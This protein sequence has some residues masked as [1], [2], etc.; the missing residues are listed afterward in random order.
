M[1]GNIFHILNRGVEKRK[2]YMHNKDYVRF[3]HDLYDFNDIQNAVQSYY[4]RREDL[5]NLTDVRHP[6]RELVDILCWA[7]MPNHPHLMVMEKEVGNA[8]LFSKKMF[9][10]YTKYFNEQNDR[11]GVLFQGK[12]K[13][14]LV[15]KDRHFLYLPFYIHLNPLD[16]FQSN[17]KEDGIKD[18]KGAIK[19][20][21]EYRWSNYGDIIGVGNK[22]FENVA[23][24]KLFFELFNTNEKKYKHDFEE[25]LRSNECRKDSDF[26][27]F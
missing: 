10:G 9:G 4:R 19:F 12:S 2:V 3:A 24:K 18:L 1:I 7:L 6:S 20:L 13:I 22:E 21:E 26:F 14:I 17:W 8:S 25:W 16:L 27:E 5:V 15:E 11:S 23:N